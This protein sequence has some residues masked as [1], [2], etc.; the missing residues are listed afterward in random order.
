MSARRAVALAVGAAFAL[1]ACG[2]SSGTVTKREYDD[3]DSWIGTCYRTEYRTVV[4][5]VTRTTY[6]N[7]KS[8][9]TTTTQS[10]TESYQVPYSCPQ[11]DPEH[12]RLHLVE[13][14]DKGVVSVP[15]SVYG[16]CAKG[17]YYDNGEGRCDG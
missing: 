15:A 14:D 12:Y 10:V 7:G 16:A 1:S 2:I 13:G 4:R 17:D 9:T 3:A 11:Y 8:T 6:V 5:P